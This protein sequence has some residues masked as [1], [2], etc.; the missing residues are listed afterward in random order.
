MNRVTQYS[1]LWDELPGQAE[2][3]YAF[4][5][6]GFFSPTQ[7]PQ[8]VP[9][10]D[11]PA[12]ELGLAPAVVRYLRDSTVAGGLVAEIMFNAWLSHAPQE[13]KRMLVAAEAW[14]RAI[15]LGHL[16]GR[17]PIDTLPGQRAG[18][19]IL[20]ASLLEYPADQN[21]LGQLWGRA[22]ELLGFPPI[23]RSLVR[24]CN[25]DADHKRGNYY[26]A[27]RGIRQLLGT[28]EEPGELERADLLAYAKLMDLEADIGRARPIDVEAV[29]RLADEQRRI[30]EAPADAEDEEVASTT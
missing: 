27:R 21:R 16:G 25:T 26:G 9:K 24:R 6:A 5:G 7:P 10:G 17:A 8:D 12:Q 23:S 29:R 2:R 4:R 30:A 13:L 3:F 18:L 19:L 14:W 1:E 15:D 22:L 11:G 28:T 20:L